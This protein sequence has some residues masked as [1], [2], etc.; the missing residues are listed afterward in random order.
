MWHEGLAT[1]P[2]RT[3][4]GRGMPH[5]FRVDCDDPEYRRKRRATANKSL[6]L[7]KA[8][9]NHAWREGRV[10]SDDAWRRVRPFA[11]VDAPRIRY[12]TIDEITRLIN[13]CSPDFRQLVQAGI[14]TGCR[15]GEVVAMRCADYNPDAGSAYVQPGKAA[16]ARHVTLSDEGRAFF[17]QATVGR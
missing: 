6:T 5:R 14:L 13:A 17:A 12:L 10:A 1:R 2:P 8:A 7:L 16:K 15:Y 4:A 9:L 11:K 3:R